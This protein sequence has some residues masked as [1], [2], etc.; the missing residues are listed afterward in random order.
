M[1]ENSS[2]S[3][4]K[5]I[6][7]AYSSF[8]VSNKYLEERFVAPLGRV[9]HEHQVSFIN[10]I[11]KKN[12]ISEV[13]EIA[14]GPARITAEIDH[15]NSGVAIDYNES[16][17]Q[18]AHKRLQSSGKSHLW[19]LEKADAFKLDLSKTFDLVYSFRFIRHFKRKD[20]FQLYKVVRSHLKKGGFF[21]LDVVNKKVSYPVR[22]KEGLKNYKIYDKLYDKL[23][24]LDEMAQNDFDVIHLEPVQ[25]KY[26]IQRL[27][28]IYVAPRSYNLAYKLLKW[29]EYNF[30]G[31][32]NLE[33]VA[34]CRLK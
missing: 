8:S 20:R 16:M 10:H 15:I 24:F 4:R 1:T 2:L 31:K 23:E 29:I 3:D 6:A 19:T 26:N 34:L 21:I 30:S 27:V 5:S 12:H 18:V 33:W 22:L 17:L 7:N 9:L 11:I 14:C 25:N 32:G 28:Q 13:L